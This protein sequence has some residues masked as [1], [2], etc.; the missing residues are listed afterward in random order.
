MI[1][2]VFIAQ[3]RTPTILK[4]CTEDNGKNGYN[5]NCQKSTV[6]HSL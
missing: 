6:G 5:T 4:Q 3:N 2:I 1:S